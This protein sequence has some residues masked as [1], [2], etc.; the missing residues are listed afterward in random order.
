MEIGEL[1][2]YLLTPAA[3]VALIIGIA[4]VI[5]IS[6]VPSKYIPIVDVLLGLLS[7]I[8][9]YGLAMGYGIVRGLITGLALGLSACGLFNG[10]K[11]VAGMYDKDE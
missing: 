1:I 8:G 11:N 5:K 6:G 10:I 3:Q 7:G 4:E 9:V 2:T